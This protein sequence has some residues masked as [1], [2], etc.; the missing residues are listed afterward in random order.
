VTKAADTLR[1][2]LDG[3]AGGERAGAQ[4]IRGVT[5]ALVEQLTAQDKGDHAPTA[6]SIAAYAATCKDLI[7]AQTQWSEAVSRGLPAFNAVLERHGRRP[8]AFPPSVPAS[9][10][11]L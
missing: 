1:K 8:V 11:P 4:T 2:A 7:T 10:R 6:S 5:N 3:V 9:S